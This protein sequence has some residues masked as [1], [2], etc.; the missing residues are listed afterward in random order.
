VPSEFPPSGD[1]NDTRDPY[2]PVNY[3]DRFHGPVT[4]RSALANS[5]N[6]PAVK[7]LDFV[8][9]Y[10]KPDT[11]AHEGLVAFARRLGISTLNRDDYGLSLTLGGG[12]VPLVELTGAYAVFANGG[13]RVPPVAITRITD[14]NG[15]LIY[16][17][18]P[19]AGEQVVRPEHAFLIS[20]ILS[21]NEARTPAFGSDSVLNLPF[22]A[23]A[24][25]GTTN[26]F[27][28][29]WTM[30]YVPEAGGR[31]VGGKCRLLPNA[32]RQRADWRCPDLG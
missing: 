6:I 21:D 12:E 7:T 18:N 16:Q 19:P 3:D 2:K 32:E 17:Y 23:T 11:E 10:D 24:K 13:R 1:P 27:R 29:N 14:F 26:D 30:G 15:N 25:T 8:G 5:Y 28:D 31:C 4:L 22:Q 20:S 9:I